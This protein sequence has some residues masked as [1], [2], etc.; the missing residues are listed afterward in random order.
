MAIRTSVEA[1]RGCGRRKPG[2]LYLVS[3][4][5]SEPCP[6]LPLALD[7][8]PHCGQGIGPARGWTW[9]TPAVVIPAQKHGSPDHNDRCPLGID[10]YDPKLSPPL[11]DLWHRMGER[12]GLIWIGERF[13]PTPDEFMAEARKM[14]VSRRIT[15]VPHGFELGK[16]YVVLAHRK[17]IYHS[18]AELVDE[19]RAD[20]TARGQ[21]GDF[22]VEP[23]YTPGVITLF[24]PTAIEY[25][26]TGNETDEEIEALEK[27]GI[28][29]VQVIADTEQLEASYEGEDGE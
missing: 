23:G 15:A 16:T 22:S 1:A 5:L 6:R 11:P 7:R 21:T 26:V 27:R 28:Q 14:G 12:A 10:L 17:A 20:M 25:V 2:G 8:C 4:A 18:E 13:Y 19:A 3:P 29:P 9:I 24:Q